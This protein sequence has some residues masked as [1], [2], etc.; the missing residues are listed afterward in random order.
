MANGGYDHQFYD[1]ARL[2]A[3]EEKE[4]AWGLFAMATNP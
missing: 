1:T 3:L 4:N 2:D